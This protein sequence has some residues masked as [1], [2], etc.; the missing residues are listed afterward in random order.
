MATKVMAVMIFLLA[1][2]ISIGREAADTPSM[3][4][5]L[6]HGSSS[7]R[8][9][10]AI[11][12]R[13]SGEASP[14]IVNALIVALRAERDD[15]TRLCVAQALG[16]IGSPAIPF[17]KEILMEGRDK[18]MMEW[19]CVSAK[20]MGEAAAP[21]AEEIAGLSKTGGEGVRLAA[22]EALGVLGGVSPSVPVLAELADLTEPPLKYKAVLALG[23]IGEKAAASSPILT[24]MLKETKDR[25]LKRH[26]VISLGMIGA[27]DKEILSLLSSLIS[28]KDAPLDTFSAIE[29]I[30]L[31]GECLNT[32]IRMARQPADQ[33]YLP[34]V[35]ACLHDRLR[36]TRAL[37]ALVLLKM[38]G[39]HEKAIVAL[40]AL[41]IPEEPSVP[42]LKQSE[43]VVPLILCRIVEA[44]GT[45]AE[46]RHVEF[47]SRLIDSPLELLALAACKAQ[48]SAR[49][50]DIKNAVS[51]LLR[52]ARHISSVRFEALSLLG[53]TNSN[54]GDILPVL[55][56]FPKVGR[57][58]R[59]AVESAIFLL[60]NSAA[61][62][63]GQQPEPMPDQKSPPPG[64][65][66]G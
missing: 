21:L 24:R 62:V 19:A 26:L 32:M 31:K 65:D 12:I 22:V 6:L 10:A 3:L 35:E 38:Y 34:S 66:G 47:V 15:S 58:Y 42:I 25:T 43:T 55:S 46:E 20:E 9:S 49:P 1:S 27:A 5:A 17:L 59:S 64:R 37:A 30:S 57:R 45:R 56:K 36:S 16:E 39:M 14:E 40:D 7:R 44:M 48:M 41:M 63:E 28:G 33:K 52:L 51:Q 18:S 61:P 13:D 2:E 8:A 53:R 4:E 54:A 50:N 60:Q 29:G 11:K 23:R